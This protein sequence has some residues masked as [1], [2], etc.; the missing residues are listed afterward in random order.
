M[1][2]FIEIY[3]YISLWLSAVI[4]YRQYCRH[5][6]VFW[7]APVLL[8]PQTLRGELLPARGARRNA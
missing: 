4:L 1:V 3:S 8:L 7:D 2:N 5:N 6:K